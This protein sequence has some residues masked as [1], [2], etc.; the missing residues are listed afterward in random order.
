MR[1]TSRR[2]QGRRIVRLGYFAAG[3]LSAR[4]LWVGSVV[5]LKA[6]TPLVRRPSPYLS[7]P[8]SGTCF[9]PLPL[10]SKSVTRPG[11]LTTTHAFTNNPLIQLSSNYPVLT[12]HLFPSGI[13]TQIRK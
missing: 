13:L 2:L 12:C 3:S 11:I 5:L 10:Q 1:C 9:F 6:T 8:G 4:L 7:S